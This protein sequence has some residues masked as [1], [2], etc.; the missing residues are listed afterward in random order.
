[1]EM[2][3]VTYVVNAR[4]PTERAHGLQVA[5]MCEAFQ[6]LHVRT[7]LI[8]PARHQPPWLA[9]RDP[10]E[11]YAVRRAFA[12][13]TLPNLDI[14]RVE[15]WSPRTLFTM[16]HFAHGRLWAQYAARRA[17][18]LAPADLFVARDIPVAASLV[19]RGV[20]TALELHG[21]PKRW[22]LDILKSITARPSLRVIVTL[23][24]ALRQTLADRGVEMKN[25]IVLH[26]AVDLD[27]FGN[28][29]SPPPE[30]PRPLVLY[31]GHL[32]HEKGIDTLVDAAR[33]APGISV[34]C[35]GGTSD[36]I[37]RWRRRVS[38][39]G[40]DNVEFTGYVPADQIPSLQQAADLLVLP[41]S[42][43]SDHSSRYTSPMK[44]FEYMAAGRPIVATSVPAIREILSHGVNSWLVPPDDPA[45]L[46]DAFR[47]L[48]DDRVL[49]HR[50]ATRARSDVAARSWDRRAMS[51]AIAAGY[52]V[53]P[54][55]GQQDPC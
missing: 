42:G 6:R 33:L 1:M 45:A 19:R 36:D 11:F 29:A 13:H 5:R 24:D 26:D 43:L 47:T 18:R 38:E 20:P 7:A 27:R 37:A 28:G 50:L 32:F 10:L 9:G 3:S 39:E 4:F 17:S 12:V 51:L 44:L 23:T 53:R 54:V 55:R 49:R 22:S 2:T 8:H 14:F 30:R 35:V 41:N 40:P 46:A 52:F 16:A 25:A 21:A 48:V 34:K 31:T 15:R